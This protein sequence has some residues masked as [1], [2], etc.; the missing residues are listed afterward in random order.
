MKARF[1]HKNVIAN[2]IDGRALRVKL[3]SLVQHHGGDNPTLRAEAKDILGQ[4]LFR[5]RMVA[6]E[7]LEAGEDGL[8]VAILLSSVQDEILGALFDFTTT[9]II[10][11][12]NPTEGERLAICAVG[13][14]GRNTLAPSSDVDLLFLRPYKRTPWAESVIEYMLYF[15][16]DMGLKVGH[17]FR[18]ID[19]AIRLGKSDITIRTAMLDARFLL[20]DR[21]LFDEFETR[22]E[23]D[24]RRGRISEFAEA[25]LNE[26]DIR[27]KKNG[28]VRYVVEPQL[29][30]GKGGLRDLDTLYWI[31]KYTYGGKTLQ[32]IAAIIALDG[33]A[34]RHFMEAVRFL[35]TVRCH[36]HFATGRPED[37]LSFDLQ[38]ELAERLGFVSPVPG[39]GVER[40]MKRYFRVAQMV[41]ALTRILCS[42]LE[43]ENVTQTSK[44]LQRFVTKRPSSFVLTQLKATGFVL[45]AGRLDIPYESFFIEAPTRLLELFAL[46]DSTDADVHP[47]A[48]QAVWSN[49][50]LINLK[51]RQN[52]EAQNLFLKCATAEN[53]PSR[54][55]RLMNEAGVLGRFLPEFGR[56]VAQTQF[57]MYHSYTVDE[58]TLIAIDTLSNIEHGLL[59]DEH[60]LASELITKISDRRALFLALLLHDTGKGQGDQQIEGAKTARRAAKRLGLDDTEADLVA[61]LVG[62]HLEM[63]ETAQ[64]RDV[65]DPQTA[66]QFAKTVISVERLRLLLLLTVADIKA[67]GPGIWNG[68]KGQLLRDLYYETEAVLR[69]GRSDSATIVSRR[70]EKANALRND[71]KTTSHKQAHRL[72][73]FG[74]EYWSAFSIEQ[75]L[76][77][78]KALVNAKENNIG[79]QTKID[80][81]TGATHLIVFTDDHK[82]LFAAIAKGLSASGANTITSQIYTSQNGKALDIFALQDDDGKPYG[83]NDPGALRRLEDNITR[84]IKADNPPRISRRKPSLRDAVF[85][86]SPR[87]TIDNDAS[88][89]FS[90]VEVSGRDRVGLLGEI[91]SEFMK[92]DI[93]IHSAHIGAYGEQVFDTFYVENQNGGKLSKQESQQ[94]TE[95][96]KLCLQ[97]DEV[98]DVKLPGRL[99]RRA[100]ASSAR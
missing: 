77:H 8:K 55:L 65:A 85:I 1:H 6:K 46:S 83:H 16:W 15:L 78:A 28:G 44:M 56:I 23:K 40:F 42:R 52:V 93:S 34:G 60:P 91:A 27:H 18:S 89:E 30:E 12:R 80:K 75:H 64:R 98:G 86:V 50:K 88:D 2:I 57:N 29:K 74:D 20:G 19:E 17:A 71:F 45:N 39:R 95:A 79:F 5:G 41:G 48:L 33:E 62:N 35:W 63:S 43:A 4:A 3:T 25:K 92:L 54:T 31:A 72:T 59:K 38:P 26:R 84:F 10:R 7:R 96:L 32:D 13:G 82:G 61:W 22:F 81:D 97:I 14:Y 53:S 21:A 90:V 36:L 51:L 70:Q 73:E 11:S 66:A 58:H 24:L 87:V 9:H 47:N 67:V 49:L 76:L 94:L 69:G 100:P 99:L 68:W 37:R